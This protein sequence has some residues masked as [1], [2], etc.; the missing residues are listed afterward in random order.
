MDRL[1]HHFFF[2]MGHRYDF[3]KYLQVT[4]T[5]INLKVRSSQQ[6]LVRST[7]NYSKTVWGRK[8]SN[9]KGGL[10]RI[11]KVVSPGF[12]LLWKS[13]R[14]RNSWTLEGDALLLMKAPVL[15]SSK[16]TKTVINQY[17]HGC[18]VCFYWRLT[19]RI[20]VYHTESQRIL[21]IWILTMKMFRIQ[22]HI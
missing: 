21:A 9:G 22:T 14:S 19:V 13:L 20:H 1:K 2:N 16:T 11:S 12:W 3:L 15:L 18:L 6:S 5:W 10:E 4:V 8:E 7:G 17:S